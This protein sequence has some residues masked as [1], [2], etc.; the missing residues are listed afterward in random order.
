MGAMAH[1]EDALTPVAPLITVGSLLVLILG[2][3]RFGR[4]GADRS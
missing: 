3:H 1:P 4:T 2:L